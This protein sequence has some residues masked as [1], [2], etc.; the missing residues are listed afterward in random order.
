MW[1]LYTGVTLGDTTWI[2]GSPSGQS[3]GEPVQAAVTHGKV[4]V[5]LHR[6]A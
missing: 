1:S 4:W 6:L 2:E 3:R 5:S